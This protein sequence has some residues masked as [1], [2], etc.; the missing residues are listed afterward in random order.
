MPT[1]FFQPP[2]IYLFFIDDITP[3]SSASLK[4]NKNIPDIHLS[5]FSLLKVFKKIPFFTFS[6]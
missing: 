5:F 2:F 4:I 3:T 1:S 6:Y